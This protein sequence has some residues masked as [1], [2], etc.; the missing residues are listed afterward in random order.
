MSL[1]VQHLHDG[2]NRKC[3][4]KD[5]EI[6]DCR[7]RSKNGSTS[8]AKDYSLVQSR[9]SEL[10]ACVNIEE[11]DDQLVEKAFK[12]AIK[13]LNQSMAILSS[14]EDKAELLKQKLTQAVIHPYRYIHTPVHTHTH[15]HV[16]NAIFT[17]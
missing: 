1:D 17:G 14:P 12:K 3:H 6:L 2:V 9:L 4:I 8:V 5:E 16:P 15:M 11:R 13:D 7:P 10:E